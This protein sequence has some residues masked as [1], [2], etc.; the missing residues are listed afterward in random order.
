[1]YSDGKYTARR[2]LRRSSSC[3]S[4]TARSNRE[5]THLGGAGRRFG[6]KRKKQTATWGKKRDFFF[7][8]LAKTLM[9][10]VEQTARGGAGP[11]GAAAPPSA[12][13]GPHV[14]STL[15]RGGP[16]PRRGQ[17]GQSRGPCLRG[18]GGPS[19]VS[20]EVPFVVSSRDPRCS[21]SPVASA[22][23]GAG[24]PAGRKSGDERFPGGLRYLPGPAGPPRSRGVLARPDGRS[25]GGT[26]RRPPG[27]RSQAGAAPVSRGQA[28]GL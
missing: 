23:E 6:R 11:A 18:W 21:R 14:S 26:G 10:G 25:G 3:S 20:G 8:F 15:C 2:S 19:P 16:C 24:G 13:L 28:G 5:Q 7:F 9:R 4:S 22:Q 12:P 1:M 27:L 17:G